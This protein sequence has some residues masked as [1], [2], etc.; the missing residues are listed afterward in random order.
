MDEEQ[1]LGM[2][3]SCAAAFRLEWQTDPVPDEEAAFT[4]WLA[5]NP[6]L[7]SQWPMWADW[8]DFTRSLGGKITR[9]RLIDDP[10]TP[11]QEWGMW[12]IP[13]HRE[14]GDDIRCMAHSLAEVLGIPPGNW[15]MFDNQLV[16]MKGTSKTLVTDTEVIAVHLAWKE[17]ALSHTQVTA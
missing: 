4:Y 1:F 8:L 5:G 7:P 12:A 6:L 14:A 15:W 3:G 10:P 9:V 17:R 13:Y 11:Y 16:T 2:F